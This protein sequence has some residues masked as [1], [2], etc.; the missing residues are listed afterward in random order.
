MLYM[1]EMEL[2]D[3]SRV[4]EWHDWYTAHIRNLLTLD[5]YHASQR[6]EA[7]TSRSAPFLAIHD[8]IGPQLFEGSGYRTV[9]GP[10]NTNEWRDL[11]T[12]W[13][14]NLFD[15]CDAMPTVAKHETLAIIDDAA[16]LPAAYQPRATLLNC[17]GLDRNIPH[18]S[19]IV[20]AAG[21]DDS[22]LRASG[23]ELFAPLTEKM[24]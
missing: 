16:K 11:M 18:R 3:R 15:G 4:A 23:T 10:S 8:V 1:V 6:F 13:S 12:N 21:E 22:A 9:G 2:P 14:R 19:F 5:G 24:R 7:I 20:L 17:V